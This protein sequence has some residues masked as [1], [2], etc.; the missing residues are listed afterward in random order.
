M[1]CLASMPSGQPYTGPID[2]DMGPNSNRG[3]SARLKLGGYFP[4]SQP[5]DAT[6]GPANILA[7]QKWA[8]A[9]N[10]PVWTT[11]A[12]NEATYRGVAWCLNR[13]F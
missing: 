1:Q 9:N 11:G 10:Q 6:G 8:I 4:A 13:A 7:L 2:G 3:A 12:W 5:N